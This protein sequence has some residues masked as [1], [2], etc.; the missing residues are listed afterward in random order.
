MEGL[1][2]LLAVGLL[3]IVSASSMSGVKLV[4]INKDGTQGKRTMLDSLY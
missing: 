1:T 2:F 3:G 4:S